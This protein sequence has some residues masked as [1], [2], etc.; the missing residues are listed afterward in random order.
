MKFFVLLAALALSVTQAFA[1]C[2]DGQAMAESAALKE[3]TK[4]NRDAKKR[5]FFFRT[6]PVKRRWKSASAR[7]LS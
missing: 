3:A 6:L 7:L 2:E 5:V 4:T 1:S